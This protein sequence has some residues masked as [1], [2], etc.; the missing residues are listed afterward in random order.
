M[1]LIDDIRTHIDECEDPCGYCLELLRESLAKLEAS[2]C[3]RSDKLTIY[4][5]GWAQCGIHNTES[6]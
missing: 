6:I 4:S 3:L 5:T 1:N 2:C